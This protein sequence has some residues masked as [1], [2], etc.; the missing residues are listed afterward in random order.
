M[1]KGLVRLLW[2][3]GV[4]FVVLIAFGIGQP[5]IWEFIV[6]K[7]APIAT[8]ALS[9]LLIIIIAL[10]A[11]GIAAFGGGTYYI[12][13]RRIREEAIKAAE[14]EYLGTLIRLRSHV[15]ALWGRLYEGL[16]GVVPRK[17]LIAF[18]NQAIYYG[19]QA[20]LDSQRLDV[21]TQEGLILEAKNAYAMALALK[22]D[23]GTAEKA[24]ELV[25]HIQQ[26]IEK[27]PPEIRRLL[28]ETIGFVTWRLPRKRND[29]I[30]AAK[31]LKQAEDEA[32]ETQK[33]LWKKRWKQ[34]PK[35][36]L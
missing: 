19:K 13:S 28:K 5:F 24:A 30:K 26:K 31:Y 16:Q 27:Y 6:H 23:P 22:G 17:Q 9:N 8:T 21:K 32:D 10:L 18:A 29:H 7:P 25:H 2:V 36:T 12:L 1:S 3:I 20:D 15:C 11:L 35:G 33:Q 4:S 14:S 34:F